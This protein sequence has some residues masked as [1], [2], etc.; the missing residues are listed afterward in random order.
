MLYA[1]SDRFA[2]M[3]FPI[4]K[5]RPI[6]VRTCADQMAIPTIDLLDSLVSLAKTDMTTYRAYYHLHG[7]QGDVFGHM[8]TDGNAF[9]AR[10]IANR[11]LRDGVVDRL[12]QARSEPVSA[13]IRQ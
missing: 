7:P 3:N 1:G 8:T 2:V 10:Q 9:V 11:L 13:T 4:E 6:A 12:R 5:S